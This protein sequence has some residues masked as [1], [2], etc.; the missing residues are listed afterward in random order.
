MFSCEFCKISKNTFFTEHLRATASKQVTVPLQCL[1]TAKSLISSSRRTGETI[2]SNYW[3]NAKIGKSLKFSSSLSLLS[4][5]LP[6]Q[7]APLPSENSTNHP[8]IVILSPVC[9]NWILSSFYRYVFFFYNIILFVFLRLVKG[10][11]I[12]LDV[13]F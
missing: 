9:F 3:Q 7:N 6:L 10:V 8:L 11:R 5:S 13:I 12:S 1:Q 2:F 4:L